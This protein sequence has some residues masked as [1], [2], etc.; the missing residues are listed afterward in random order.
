MLPEQEGAYIHL[1]CFDWQ[2][3]GLLNDMGVLVHLSRITKDKLMF[4]LEKF[5]AHPRKE[6]W[7]THPRLE[8][9]RKKQKEFR[10]KKSVSGKQGAKKRWSKKPQAPDNQGGNDTEKPDG[11]A[12]GDA[13]NLPIAN[14]GSPSPIPSP[15]AIAIPKD[16]KKREGRKLPALADWLDY[17]KEKDY[18][19]E[20]AESAFDHY[21]ANGWK[22]KG[23]NLIKDWKAALRTCKKFYYQRN[24]N[25]TE[26]E[27]ERL[28]E[29]KKQ[30]IADD[31]PW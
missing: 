20:D 18:P 23:G 17:A 5:K 4:V 31:K 8:K 27:R 11:D 13:I 21:T 19:K 2:E 7:L 10:K 28:R 1:L 16:K 25:N 30:R 12:N 22:Q 3:D 26:S 14:D 9:E 29:E 15:S 24:F 6:G